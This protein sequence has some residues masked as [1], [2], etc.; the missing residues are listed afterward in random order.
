VHGRTGEKKRRKERTESKGR[1]KDGARGRVKR[2]KSLKVTG[3]VGAIGIR[4]LVE[5]TRR[6]WQV[7]S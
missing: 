2:E 4:C 7:G 5:S 1:G 6:K 3:L